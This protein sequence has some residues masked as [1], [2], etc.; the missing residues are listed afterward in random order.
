MAAYTGRQDSTAPGHEEKGDSTVE[1]EQLGN[2]L[3]R[4]GLRT[5]LAPDDNDRPVLEVT[6]RA[7]TGIGVTAVHVWRQGGVF[8]WEGGTLALEDSAADITRAT[9]QIA[10]EFRWTSHGQS[11]PLEPAS[12]PGAT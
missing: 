5:T 2:E 1:L 9:D 12:D 4:R 7:T 8:W 11:F 3:S 10:K 6:R